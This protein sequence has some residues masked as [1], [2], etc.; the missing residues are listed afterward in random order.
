[1]FKMPNSN[2]LGRPETDTS[3]MTTSSGL[4]PPELSMRMP[5]RLPGGQGE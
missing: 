3:W 1:V 2:W 4:D 5:A